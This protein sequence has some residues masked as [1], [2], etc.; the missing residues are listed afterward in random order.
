MEN[1]IDLLVVG[2]GPAGL[3]AAVQ[4]ASE[5]LKTR[6]LEQFD[7]AGGQAK[8]SSRVENFP[9]FPNGITGAALM[10]RFE[11]QAERFGAKLETKVG[12]KSF[13]TEGDLFFVRLTNNEQIV[14]K[15]ILISCGLTPRKLPALA[16]FEGNGVFYGAMPNEAKN[17][18]GKNVTV[19]GGANS[20]GQAAVNF[21]QYA[22]V[23]MIVRTPDLE[24]GMSQY[25]IDKIT[26]N[27]NI[28]VKFNAEI[29]GLNGSAS[30]ESATLRSGEVIKSDAVFVFIGFQ[31]NASWLNDAC[32]LDERGYIKCSENF[33]T[34]T[35]GI[36]VAGDVRSGA[37]DRMI[38]SAG[39]AAEAVSFI[40]KYLASLTF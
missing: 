40:H 10:S 25:L 26:A 21:A 8:Y 3:T 20:A 28:E 2:A 16:N 31:P 4:S 29:S 7:V 30:L 33:M 24:V 1:L 38:T 27:P 39:N 19:V 17:W 14:T 6:V 36:F 13:K 15:T 22:K 32:E 12:V 5:G 11:H 35:K 37:V 9:G 34:T 18:A 23:T